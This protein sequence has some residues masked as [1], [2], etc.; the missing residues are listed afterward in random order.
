MEFDRL[1]FTQQVV[2]GATLITA[3][4]D[5]VGSKFKDRFSVVKKLKTAAEA[6]YA[7]SQESSSQ[8]ECC[9]TEDTSSNLEYDSRF[10]QKVDLTT[11]CIAISGS[12]PSN[13]RYLDDTFVDEMKK[14][15]NDHPFIKW[16]Y[17]GSEDGVLTN[18]PAFQLSNDCS[19]YDP[20]FRPWY[21]E[22]ATPEP[23]DVVLVIDTSGSMSGSR[24][25][26]AKD[27]AVT[28]LSTMNPRDR[29]SAKTLFT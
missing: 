3:V 2:D 13:R 25:G 27:A 21:V 15:L 16:Q 18:F 23:N 12:A 7:R 1:Q 9:K 8:W 11:G 28:V 17:F 10:R 22:T 29:V 20:R 6:S 26:V 24:I 5:K 14:I 19:G 4:A